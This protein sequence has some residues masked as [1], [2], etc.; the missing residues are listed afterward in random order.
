MK[1]ALTLIYL[2]IAFSASPAYGYTRPHRH[3]TKLR[4]SRVSSLT[5][6]AVSIGE[7]EQ[8]IRPTKAIKEAIDATKK[9]GA[10]SFRA[11]MAW[12]VVEKLECAYKN[13][14]N[15]NEEKSGVFTGDKS[16]S[17]RDYI[18]DDATYDAVESNLSDLK[19]LI[20][21][22]MTKVTDMKNIAN[23]IKEASHSPRPTSKR[24]SIEAISAAR[25]ATR[26]YGIHS[27]QTTL[28]WEA[29]EE[30]LSNDLDDLAP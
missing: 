22:E 4:R 17:R 12:G 18:T 23:K 28:A 27:V 10:T 6:L 13:S 25:E 26:E 16:D 11:R 24:K 3:M 30:I 20:D 21:E 7:G 5:P 1:T 15:K 14:S 8:D 19:S 9:H 29:F 2:A